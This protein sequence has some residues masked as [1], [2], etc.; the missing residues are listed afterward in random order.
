MPCPDN[1][2]QQE[3]SPCRGTAS[4]Y[5]D[6][7]ANLIIAVPRQPCSARNITL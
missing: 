1:H 3:I 7:S 2:V 5:F 4:E 6:G